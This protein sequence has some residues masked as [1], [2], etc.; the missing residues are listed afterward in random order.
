M[1]EQ[2]FFYSELFASLQGEGSLIG[3][4]SVF[5]R[6]SGCN[7]RCSWCDTPYTSW[8]PEGK[9]IRVSDAAE[10]ILSFGLRHVVIT[11]GEPFL[12]P[13]PL[14]QL[15]AILHEAGRHLTIE[16]NGTRFHPVTA[17]LISLSP[18]LRNST[19]TDAPAS[20]VRRH[21]R[22]RLQREVLRRFFKEHACQV[23]FVVDRPEDLA[24]I[25]TLIAQVPIPP[26][27]VFLMPQGRTWEELRPKMEWLAEVCLRRG[28]RL[29]PRLQ[30]EIWGD[31]RGV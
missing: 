17:D 13:E 5:F 26:E 23:K 30:I 27:T 16:T 19:P 3:T 21:E 28:Y 18:K 7:L 8:K 14:A 9:R 6:L 2:T 12:Q 15:C 1:R 24:E 20:L 11:G 10:A 22:E 4:P 29:S 25:E 31:R